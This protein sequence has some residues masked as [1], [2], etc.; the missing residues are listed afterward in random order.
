MAITFIETVERY[1]DGS[2]WIARYNVNGY[3]WDADFVNH[4][5]NTTPHTLRPQYGHNRRI[6]GAMASARKAVERAHRDLV[7]QD[8]AFMAAHRALYND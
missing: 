1:E 2:G 8:A 6:K 5:V 7:E 3:L 4:R